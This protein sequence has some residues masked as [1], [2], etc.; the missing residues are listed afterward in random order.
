MSGWIVPHAG[1]GWMSTS[2]CTD[3]AASSRAAAAAAS[4]DLRLVPLI[5]RANGYAYTFPQEEQL[6]SFRHEIL[7]VDV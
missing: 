7:I 2:P 3:F 4:G 6:C 5:V 1:H